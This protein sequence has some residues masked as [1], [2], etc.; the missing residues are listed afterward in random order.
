MSVNYIGCYADAI[1]TTTGCGTNGQFNSAPGR[2]LP[3]CTS[4]SVMSI[5]LCMGYAIDLV[6]TVFSLQYGKE[7]YI[8]NNLY[9][10]TSLGQSGGCSMTCPGNVDKVC[11]GSWANQVY[12]LTTP[13]PT[14]TTTTPTPT[15]TP[16]QTPIHM[17]TS[18][19]PTTTPVVLIVGLVIGFVFA[20]A[21]CGLYILSCSQSNATAPEPQQVTTAPQL[22]N[23]R[24]FDVENP[25]PSAPPLPTAATTPT[26]PASKALP[27][28]RIPPR[29]ATTFLPSAPPLQEIDEEYPAMF[30][31]P[32]THDIMTEPV[33]ASDGQTYEKDTIQHWI[34]TGRNVSPMTNQPLANNQLVP[35]YNLKSAIASYKTQHI[36]QIRQAI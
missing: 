3:Y 35:N 22:Q 16:T 24:D 5:D 7:C 23:Y 30:L 28:L 31:C 13:T 29:A 1:V 4:T 18:T 10:A 11:G 36:R 17:S 32:I 15:P 33:I 14:P 9:Y 2:L 26:T 25:A 19:T 27:P 12:A 34:H 21:A 8:G 6:Y 20:I